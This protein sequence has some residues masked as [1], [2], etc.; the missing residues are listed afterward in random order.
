MVATLSLAGR[1]VVASA[2]LGMSLVMSAASAMAVEP[3][4]G[5]P[6]FV[7]LSLLVA[8]GYPCQWPT[9][10]RYHVAPEERIGPLSPYNVD[11][12]YIDGNMGTQLDVPP[13][14]VAPPDS[15]LPQAGRFGAAYTETIA[16]WQF[17]GEACVLDIR[18]L[19]DAAPPGR[20]ALVRADRVR[21]WEGQHRRLR[22]GD[23][24]LFHSGYS[25]AYFR[26]LPEGRRYAADPVE[27]ASPAW[28]DPEPGC[29][30]YLAG[31][32][33]MTLGTDSTSMGPLPDLGEPTHYAGLKHGLIWAESLTGLG[34][35]PPVGAF[36]A[37]LSPKFAGDPYSEARAFAIVGDP[38]ASRLI[39]AAR[40]KRAV[41]LS[42][43]LSEDLPVAWPGRG[44]GRHRPPYQKVR[45]SFNP[46]TGSPQV[47]HLLG[48]DTGTHLVPPSYAL[49]PAGFD[50]ATYAPEV[51]G[52]LAEYEAK[53]GAR[54]TSEVTT[55]KVPI[56][57]GCG[58]IRVID[59]THRLG[60]LDR[61]LWPASPEIT[62]ADI[63]RDEKAYGA[64]RPGDVVV[65]RSGW[66]DRHFRPLPEGKACMDDPLN[67][68]SEGWPALGPE[69]VVALAKR[70]IRCVAIDAPTLGGVEP[71]KAIMTYWALG[72]RGMIGVEFLKDVG[73]VPAGAY[74]LFAPLK[75]QGGHGG[76]GRAI[77]LIPE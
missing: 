12:L 5:G 21:D 20:S 16:P 22:F 71:K 73:K 72:S 60:T 27:G 6:K 14:S 37:M 68:K 7:D 30:E 59:V 46:N 34:S 61:A 53:Y 11:A 2:A 52:W 40:G 77:A 4:D 65:F 49:P 41:D 43:T 31:Q 44:T 67:G 17:C 69:A 48:S 51:R 64:L 58:P 19:R 15:K 35:L 62:L 9:F 56:A 38:L 76:P 45:F 28:P 13:H 25:D 54:G 39:D 33:V 74:F 29:M 26:P 57:Q 8:P 70:G 63:E 23:V 47:A 10:A 3:G 50:D 1:R 42:V 24:L 75:L 66:N 18:D 32:G 55:E 36:Y